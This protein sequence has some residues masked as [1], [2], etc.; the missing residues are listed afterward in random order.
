MST[1]GEG[2]ERRMWTKAPPL[3]G[4][5]GNARW[6]LIEAQTNPR[7]K[8][9]L[10]VPV[11]VELL[12]PALENLDQFVAFLA[13]ATDQYSLPD[14]VMDRLQSEAETPRREDGPL[15]LTFLSR[16]DSV[17]SR[18]WT[19]VSVGPPQARIY[20]TDGFRPGKPIRVKTGPLSCTPVVG[21]L[22]DSIGFLNHRFR[23]AD[24]TTRFAGLWIMHNDTLAGDPGP[25]VMPAIS[26]IELTTSHINMRLASQRSELALYRQINMGVFGPATRHGTA[27]HA[28]HGTHVLDTA[29]GAEPGT[30]MSEVPILGVQLPPSSIGETS[31]AELNPDIMRGL[32]WVI[33]RALQMPGRF[34]LVIN[35]SLGALA[36]PQDGTSKI[37]DWIIREIKRYHLF[38]GGAPIRIVIAYGNAHKARLVANVTLEPGQGVQLDWHILP[39]D[40]TRSVLEVRSA[41]GQATQLGLQV[42]PPDAGPALALAPWPAP[43]VVLQYAVP[44]GVVAEVEP[45]VEAQSDKLAITVAPTLRHDTRPYACSGV[46]R[47]RLQNNGSTAANVTCKVQRDDTPGGYRRTG[48]QSWLDHPTAWDW[49]AETRAYSLPGPTCPVTR[50]GTEVSYAGF[51]HPSAYFVGA[52]RPDLKVS[53]AVRPSSY[54]AEGAS[55]PPD[56]PTLSGMGDQG[57]V[58]SGQRE[59][60][61][62]SGSTSRLS[63]TSVATPQVS[64]K[65]LEYAMA[66]QMTAQI[67]GPHDAAELAYCLAPKAPAPVADTRL[68]FGTVIPA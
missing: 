42:T 26:G 16:P 33:T 6:N 68:G 13:K 45:L 53:G 58:L 41:T 10:V 23:R 32:D 17:E 12:P 62:L 67:S 46:W 4:I 61:V 56:S 5:T 54:T 40:T 49:E 66:G 50:Q 7:V 63:G 14:H 35:L 51:H 9:E 55:P 24:G 27:F 15:Q 3:P 60:G 21:I 44:S 48:R 47:V 36:G 43:G 57:S 52:A 39:D 1:K 38:S 59:A 19:V 31:G 25:H 34:P 37:E 18:Y 29:A 22:D 20:R 65:L 8:S 28:G 11:F 30:P 2:E 64:R